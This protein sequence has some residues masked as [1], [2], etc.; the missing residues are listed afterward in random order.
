MK[1]SHI[2]FE[3]ALSNTSDTDDRSQVA[4]QADEQAVCKF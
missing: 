1:V 2:E 3:D 4:S